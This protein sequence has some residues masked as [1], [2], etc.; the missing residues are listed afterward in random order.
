MLR[1]LL[2]LA[3]VAPF[4]HA[5]PRD[6]P[7]TWTTRTARA[8]EHAVEAWLTPRLERTPDFVQFDLRV[9]WV[10]GVAD[11]LESQ[12]SLDVDLTHTQGSDTGNARLSS[13]WRWTTRRREGSP[14]GFST[15]GRLS[16]GPSMF[17]AEGRLVMDLE[18]GRFLLSANVSFAKAVLWGHLAGADTHL[19]EN[20]ALRFAVAS[21][22]NIGLEGRARSGWE[23]REYYGTGIY[24]GP[25]VAFSFDS[26]WVTVGLQAQVA[27]DKSRPELENTLEPLTLRDNERFVLRLA[28]GAK[29][30]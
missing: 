13:L 29:A 18:A 1:P 24:V 8:Q 6:F 26:F 12:L 9:A 14:F 21:F 22:A 11:T 28:F 27:A 4:A 7:F 3:L 25:S 20:L 5:A 23:A 2:L 19:E 17:E 30:L 10:Y 15:Q 16:L